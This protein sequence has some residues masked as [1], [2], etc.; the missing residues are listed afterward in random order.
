MANPEPNIERI[1]RDLSIELGNVSNA[2]GAQGV[3]QLVPNFDGNPETG[4]KK[5]KNSPKFQI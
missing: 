4:L 2:L 5:L 1:F 3:A